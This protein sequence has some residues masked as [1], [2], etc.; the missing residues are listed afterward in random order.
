MSV[1]HEKHDSGFGVVEI[2]VSMF[3][4]ALLAIAFLPLLMQSLRVSVSNSTLATAT[5]LVAQEMEELR[6]LGTTCS[7]L[8]DYASSSSSTVTVSGSQVLNVTIDITCPSTTTVLP[9]TVTATVSVIEEPDTVP[10]ASA[11]T[12]MLVENH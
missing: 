2:V 9:T 7:T 6:S 1:S 4:L 10:I 5:Q 8:D 3:L 11:T 12:L